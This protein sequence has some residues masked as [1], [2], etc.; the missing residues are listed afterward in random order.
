VYGSNEIAT[1]GTN[2]KRKRGKH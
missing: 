2:Q 1:K